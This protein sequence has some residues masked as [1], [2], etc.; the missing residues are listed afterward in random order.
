[1]YKCTVY[2]GRDVGG[3]DGYG[4]MGFIEEEGRAERTDGAFSFASPNRIG[5]VQ[6]RK[7]EKKN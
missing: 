5:L 3:R 7:R 2:T 1:M 4:G 6:T